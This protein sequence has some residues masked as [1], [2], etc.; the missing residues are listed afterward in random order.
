MIYNYSISQVGAA[1]A[2]I[3]LNLNTF[4][5]IIGAA[6]FLSEAIQPAH[7]IGF[8]FIV[9]GVI[10]GSGTLEALLLKKRKVEIA[11]DTSLSK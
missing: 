1:E 3:F 8:I 2:S 11:T 9:S 7:Y 6:L 4:F 5:S 10:M